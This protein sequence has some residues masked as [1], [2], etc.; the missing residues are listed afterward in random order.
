[1]LDPYIRM[2]KAFVPRKMCEAHWH[3]VMG[4][5]LKRKQ[6]LIH[7]GIFI[8]GDNPAERKAVGEV[9]ISSLDFRK[10]GS[11]NLMIT[12]FRGFLLPYEFLNELRHLWKNE[13]VKP[14]AFVFRQYLWNGGKRPAGGRRR[15][16]DQCGGCGG[17]KRAYRQRGLGPLPDGIRHQGCGRGRFRTVSR[18]HPSEDSYLLIPMKPLATRLRE[19]VC[20]LGRRVDPV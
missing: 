15:N 17:Y 19:E 12:Q 11:L 18:R 14:N 20:Y 13:G 5:D 7:L 1:L 3:Q 10:M 4:G 16:R 2:S 9:D 8:R 6:K